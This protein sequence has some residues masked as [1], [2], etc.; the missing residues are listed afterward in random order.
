[1]ADQTDLEVNGKGTSALSASAEEKLSKSPVVS[2]EPED[3]TPEA[4]I[5]ELHVHQIELEM[6]NEELNRVQ[7]ELEESRDKRQGLYDFAPVGYFTLT[8]NGIIKDVN[9]T[10]ATLLGMPRPKLI[11]RGFGCLLGWIESRRR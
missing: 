11:G 8:H 9:L 10:G 5:H 4:I 1:M 6:Q 7:L 2:A 3:K